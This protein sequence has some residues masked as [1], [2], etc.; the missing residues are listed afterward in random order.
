M[1][2]KIILLTTLLLLFTGCLSTPSSPPEYNWDT[3]EEIT[4]N[5]KNQTYTSTIKTNNTIELWQRASLGGEEPLNIIDPKFRYQNGTI[6]NLTTK[7]EGD[8]TKITPPTEGSISYTSE[9]TTRRFSQ[10]I[11]K[12]GS[13]KVV[14]PNGKD[15][16]NPI[17]GRISPGNYEITSENPLTIKWQEVEKGAIIEIGHYGKN[18]PT[19]FYYFIGILSISAI[20]IILYYKRKL[21][22]LKQ[23][24]KNKYK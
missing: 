6:I 19:I 14:L 16:R 8:R 4:F 23:N 1:K 15:A 11:P 5:L 22:T 10:P 2:K 20:I 3:S 17:L 12:T 7:Q 9:K 18:D 21:K 24:V 13:V